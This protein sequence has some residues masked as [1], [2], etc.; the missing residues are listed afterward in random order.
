MFI[1]NFIACM[2]NSHSMYNYNVIVFPF[3]KPHTFLY[4]YTDARL[5][6]VYVRPAIDNDYVKKVKYTITWEIQVF[7]Q[8]IK[9]YIQSAY[10]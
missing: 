5:K 9:L 4:N 6:F 3:L 2:Q 10:N 8:P 1:V 7:Y